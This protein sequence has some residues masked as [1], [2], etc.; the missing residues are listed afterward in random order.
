MI[1][2][3]ISHYRIL[4]RLGSGGMGV[5]YK[6]EDTRLTRFVALKFVSDDLT[7][8]SQLLQRFE[9]EARAAGS[10][11]H[12]GICTIHDIEDNHGHPFIVMEFLEGRNF[13]TLIAGKPVELEL[14]LDLA[15]QIAEALDAAHTK[16]IIHRDIKPANLFLTARGVAKIV[17]FGLAKLSLSR[18]SEALGDSRAEGETISKQ[19]SRGELVGTVAY[20]SPEQAR[21]EAVDG[22]SDIFSFGAVLYEMAT[23]RQAFGGKAM[24]VVFHSILA[25]EPTPVR[26]LSPQMPLDLERIIRKALQKNREMRY[27]SASDL[28][29]DLRGL[30]RDLESG[31]ITPG[32]NTPPPLTNPGS[33]TGVSRKRSARAIRSLAVLPFV[34]ENRDS[35]IDYLTDGITE[36]I[37]HALAEIPKLRIQAR[38]TVFRFKSRLDDPQGVG[39]ELNVQAVLTG[40]LMQRGDALTVSAE[41]VDVLDGSCLWGARFNRPQSEI[42]VMQ[43]EI[44]A[45]ISQKLQLH[46]SG[47]QKKRLDRR[48]TRDLEAY[49]L[50]L[51]GRY[52]WNKRTVDGLINAIN[53]F[54]QAISRD[55]GFALAHAG[56]ADCFHPLGAYRVLSPAEAFGKAKAAALKALEIDDR[57]AEAHTS[58]AMSILFYDWNWA[59]AEQSFKRAIQLNPNYPIAYQWYA[60]HL[61]AMG[62]QEESLAAILHAQKLDPL[63]LPI[64][65]HLGWAYYF[66]RDFDQ[67]EK[68]LRKTIELDENFV[69][70]RFILGQVLTQQG[71]YEEAIS[72]LDS[73]LSQSPGLPSILSAIGYSAALAGNEAKALEIL[74]QLGEQQK[75]RYVSP[76]E[77][78][79]VHIGMADKDKAF[80]YLQ[81]ALKDRSSWLIWL[82]VEPTFDLLRSDPRFAALLF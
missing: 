13:N 63:S 39:R 66:V 12:P 59:S 58:L 24:A 78:A 45:E 11:A 62:R 77:F 65:T 49:H 54:G 5:V 44:A 30:K 16:G 32:T 51:K 28:R 9:R 23:G 1:G 57:I 71:R 34:N 7:G 74:G 33:S 38:S 75:K 14:L 53:F 20:M 73:S 21:G 67:A 37:I 8:N 61:M 60:V 15:I 82:K 19:L 3:T 70:A 22:R 41:L 10:L 31:R 26:S 6:A 4:E 80:A 47:D 40:R 17:D 68:Q 43:D 55:P 64:N 36:T 72:E 29:A 48:Y 50:Y 35:N 69:L 27:E 2:E 18:V 79:L 76:Y 56:L 25:E 81:E 42:F 52:Y 46:L